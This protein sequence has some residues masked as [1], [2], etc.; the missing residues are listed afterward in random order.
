MRLTV[1]ET[2]DSTKVT[3]NPESAKTDPAKG[4]VQS[5]DIVAGAKVEPVGLDESRKA[6]TAPAPALLEG[7]LA[8]ADKPKTE[9]SQSGKD[10]AAQLV[11]AWDGINDD[12][13]VRKVLHAAKDGGYIED[14]NQALIAT[15]GKAL[16]L[17]IKEQHDGASQREYLN[18]ALPYDASRQAQVVHDAIDNFSGDRENAQ[19]KAVLEQALT[20]MYQS[21]KLADT[22]ANYKNYTG[23]DFAL[24]ME[25][26]VKSGA[27]PGAEVDSY[28]DTFMGQDAA[29]DRGVLK[30]SEDRLKELR[31]AKY[32]DHDVSEERDSIIARIERVVLKGITPE[33]LTAEAYLEKLDSENIISGTE[34]WK[35]LG[36]ISAEKAAQ[37]KQESD[38]AAAEAAALAEKEALA[39][40]EQEVTVAERPESIYIVKKGDCLIRIARHH[41]ISLE[42]L[43]VANPKY[44]ANPKMVWVGAKIIIPGKH[45]LAEKEE[46]AKAA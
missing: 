32:E 40:K 3:T 7:G 34:K 6:Q 5:F 11:K 20:G 24:D 21:G 15:T 39:K 12:S 17:H 44:R 33:G 16:A 4:E 28:V 38:R 42:E 1:P 2:T 35:I 46:E 13:T 37:L 14:V 29:R 43:L 41:G 36:S 18:L 22:L 31:K 26:L 45:E 19:K 8:G 25:K 23:Q 27:V 10:A 30:K 9:P